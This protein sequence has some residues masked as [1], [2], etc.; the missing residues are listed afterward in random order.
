MVIGTTKM[1]CLKLPEGY[2][3]VVLAA[4]GNT[5]VNVWLGINVSRARKQYGIEYPT[6]YSPDNNMFNCIQRAHQNTLENHPNL[7]YLLLFSGLEFPKLSAGAGVVYMLGR[8]FYAKGYYTGDPKNRR[9]GGF[10]HLAEL[11]LLGGTLSWVFHQLQWHAC[12]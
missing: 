7:I 10:G 11:F 5:F 6:M 1:M 3:Y 8:I 4:V 12:C 2:G 9:Y